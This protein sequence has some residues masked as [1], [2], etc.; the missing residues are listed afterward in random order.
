M[1]ADILTALIVV[2]LGAFTGTAAGLLVGYCAKTQGRDW[3]VM[4]Q[5]DKRTN[6]ALVIVCS[7][8]CIAGLAW[9]AFS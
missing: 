8:T 4:S 2:T 6:I 3:A 1:A 5:K 9:Y 7:V